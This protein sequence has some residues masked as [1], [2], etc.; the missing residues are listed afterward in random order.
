MSFLSMCQLAVRR[1]GQFSER[2]A[3]IFSDYQISIPEEYWNRNA[4]GWDLGQNY[5]TTY[6]HKYTLQLHT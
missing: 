6:I 1:A 3:V 4:R 5:N 2:L